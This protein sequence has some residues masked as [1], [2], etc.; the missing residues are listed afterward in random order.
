[1]EIECKEYENKINCGAYNQIID[2]KVELEKWK[3]AKL[4]DGPKFGKKEILLS[5]AIEKLTV[6][7]AEQIA[8]QCQ[9][10]YFFELKYSVH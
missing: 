1:M 4:R 2:I 8:D 5:R 9:S 10:K 7:A 3:C 6:K